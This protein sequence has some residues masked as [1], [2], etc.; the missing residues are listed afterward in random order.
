MNKITRPDPEQYSDFDDYCDALRNLKSLTP[1]EYSCLLQ[2]DL[3]WCEEHHHETVTQYRSECAMFGDAGPG[4]GL[5]VAN[6]ARRL[7]ELRA[8]LARVRR[9]IANSQQ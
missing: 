4:Q 5:D 9:V 3:Y 8:K 7:S 2:Q 6:G 1:V